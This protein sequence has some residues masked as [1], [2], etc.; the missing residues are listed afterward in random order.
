MLNPFDALGLSE[1]YARRPFGLLSEVPAVA[2]VQKRSSAALSPRSSAAHRAHI[3]QHAFAITDHVNR[4][5]GVLY[6]RKIVGE[7]RHRIDMPAAP[8]RACV[9]V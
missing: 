2:L 1:Y 5:V 7:R 9:T 4:L 8:F 6:H 3:V